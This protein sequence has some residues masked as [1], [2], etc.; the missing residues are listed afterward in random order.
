M[1]WLMWEAKAPADRTD[2]LLAWV[3]RQA[4]ADA[5]VYRSVDRVVVIAEGLHALPDPPEHLVARPAHAWR[6][7]R[8]R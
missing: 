1:S 3:Q 6:F 4:P 8:V 2:A 5:Q 7:E